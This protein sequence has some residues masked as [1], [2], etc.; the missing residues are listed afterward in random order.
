[1]GWISC[2]GFARIW[3]VQ[4]SPPHAIPYPRKAKAHSTPYS[5]AQ[6]WMCLC[7]GRKWLLGWLTCLPEKGTGRKAKN[8]VQLSLCFCFPGEEDPFLGAVSSFLNPQSSLC[9]AVIWLRGQLRA[10][11]ISGQEKPR[12]RRAP[13]GP[14]AWE[15]QLKWGPGPQ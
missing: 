13:T 15:G 5:Q 6:R 14:R 8:S 12:H 9:P 7:H 1:M 2:L 3:R 4:E 11:I 10:C